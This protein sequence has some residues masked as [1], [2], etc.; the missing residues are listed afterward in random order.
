MKRIRLFGGRSVP[1]A[2]VALLGVE[3]ALQVAAPLLDAALLRH[4]LLRSTRHAP[5]AQYVGQLGDDEGSFYRLHRDGGN[6]SLD[7]PG[8]MWILGGRPPGIEGFRV[9]EALAAGLSKDGGGVTVVD[10]TQPGYVMGQSVAL[11]LEML[12]GH[13]R[14]RRPQR[15]VFLAGPF[16]L[17]A[18]IV[19]Y[20]VMVEEIRDIFEYRVGGYPFLRA[21]ADAR[22]KSVVV[23]DHVLNLPFRR[24]GMAIGDLSPLPP[25]PAQEGLQAKARAVVADVLFQSGLA[26][27]V[28]HEFGI[29]CTFVWDTSVT[30][31][32][33]RS[34]REAHAKSPDDLESLRAAVEEAL[35]QW[36]APASPRSPAML[37]I[38]AEDLDSFVR[39][40]SDAVRG[41]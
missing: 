26:D 10:L 21:L 34:W 22:I 40:V 18:P 27:V 37:R 36:S 8:L 23:L 41:G 12:R 3:A 7:D 11:F 31:E 30:W 19:G 25:L 35:G 28:C 17:A 16:D 33:T 39:Q 2:L 32:E 29:R 13:S 9:S 24:E 14:D 4:D 5:H 1:V 20:P 38:H 6:P 15:A